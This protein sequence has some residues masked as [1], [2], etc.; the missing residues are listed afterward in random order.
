MILVLAYHSVSDYDYLYAVSAEKFRKQLVYL[1]KKFKIISV[2]ELENILK[3]K[4]KIKEN[5]AVITFDDGLEDNYLNA[6]PILRELKIPATIFM[7][8]SLLGGSI[9]NDRGFYFKFLSKEQIIEMSKDEMIIFGSHTHKHPLL[10]SLQA[11]EVDQELKVAKNI[12]EGIVNKDIKYFAYPKGK[13]NTE[14]L[15]IVKNYHRLAFGTRGFIQDASAVN[16]LA[17]PR[18]IVYN[19]NIWKFRLQVSKFYQSLRNKLYG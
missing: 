18:M 5:L 6:W 8:T 19:N 4:Q 10:T 3:D 11:P 13:F 15:G 2:E 9:T 16:F 12:L 7:T 14:V 1:K 17:I